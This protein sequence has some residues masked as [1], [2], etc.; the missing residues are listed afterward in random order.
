MLHLHAP[1]L[2][3]AEMAAGYRNGRSSANLMYHFILL[4]SVLIAQM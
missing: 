4:T 1:L 3:I 2:S